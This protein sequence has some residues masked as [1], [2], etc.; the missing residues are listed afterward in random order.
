M[1]D[2]MPFQILSAMITPAVLISASGLLVLSTSNRLSRVVDRVRNLADKA[3]AM[4]QAAKVDAD[5]KSWLLDQLALLGRR[6][7]LLRS[8]LTSLYLA[9]TMFVL[10]S[11]S[12]GVLSPFSPRYGWIPV[13]S[14]LI[15]SG[16]LLFGSV[17]LIS[18]GR[19]A[20]DSTLQEMNYLRRSV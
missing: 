20:I 19:T 14:G 12:L 7:I 15:G 5:Y 4:S 9:I 6:A 1:N 18:E 3:A 16:I 11:I 2:S 13:T 8:A 10:T 17:L